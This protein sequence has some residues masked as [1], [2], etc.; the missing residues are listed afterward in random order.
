WHAW[1]RRLSGGSVSQSGTNKVLRKKV[2]RSR[3]K[4]TYSRA[5]TAKLTDSH[6]PVEI[7][8]WRRNS[9]ALEVR[10]RFPC[11]LHRHVAQISLFMS[12]LSADI[13]RGQLSRDEMNMQEG[14]YMYRYRY[15]GGGASQLVLAH[16]GRLKLEKGSVS[17]KS[18]PRLR[19]V[20]FPRCQSAAFNHPNH[21]IFVGQLGALVATTVEHVV[22]PDVRC[23]NSY[24]SIN[25]STN[26]LL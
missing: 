12:F 21:E 15:N 13:G 17:S 11:H 10:P 16:M 18:L 3:P 22:A 8:R 2:H 1:I 9:R 26:F 7:R 20:M 5:L 24:M 4:L 23:V 25:M 14:S 6:L 19:N